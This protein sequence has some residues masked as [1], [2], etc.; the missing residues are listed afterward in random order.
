MILD[1]VHIQP[2]QLLFIMRNRTESSLNFVAQQLWIWYDD[3]MMLQLI[4]SILVVW[5]I[6]Y[7]IQRMI[8]MV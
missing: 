5:V 8:M 3:H 7:A 2:R 4:A 6:I 1:V